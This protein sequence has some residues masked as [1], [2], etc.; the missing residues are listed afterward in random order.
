[1]KN[2][3]L[4]AAS[5]GFILMNSCQ[6]NPINSDVKLVQDEKVIAKR[7]NYAGVISIL[8]GG[9]HHCTAT[10]VSADL[11]LTA[12]HCV[13]ISSWHRGEF[14][15]RTNYKEFNIDI[16]DPT[17]RSVKLQLKPVGFQ[18]S[19]DT[20]D[21]EA[22]D[23]L[24]FPGFTQQQVTNLNA[25]P[26]VGFIRVKPTEQFDAE[27]DIWP[28]SFGA[29]VSTGK[30]ESAVTVGGFGCQT[31]TESDVGEREFPYLVDM[32]SQAWKP[33]DFFN[34][35]KFQL[36]NGSEDF[37]DYVGTG[38][39][40]NPSVGERKL[41]DAS[42]FFTEGDA[43]NNKR[44]ALCPGD[45][46]GGVY[47]QREGFQTLVIGVNSSMGAKDRSETDESKAKGSFYNVHGKWKEGTDNYFGISNWMQ[48]VFLGA[49]DNPEK[50]FA[51]GY[52][53][54]EIRQ[55]Y[56][57]DAEESG[58]YDAKMTVP[59][60][61]RGMLPKAL[62]VV[63]FNHDLSKELPIIS[64]KDFSTGQYLNKLSEENTFAFTEDIN[65]NFEV[66]VKGT[67]EQQ[68]S[69]YLFVYPIF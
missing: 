15:G 51:V 38:L 43:L 61:T 35:Y 2:I 29:G 47:L 19:S 64:V 24:P 25:G 39:Q 23:F 36:T 34:R 4:I 68:G 28:I 21:V 66:L 1:M 56:F 14:Y 20:I 27:F 16:Y 30:Y 8:K 67:A 45:S 48:W 9:K 13:G 42:F 6:K 65:G 11:I 5:S 63:A 31:K 46:G 7:E 10:R 57:Y 18:D 37:L 50:R 44:G 33:S 60:D 53:V 26:D 55:N 58:P 17:K 3:G 41:I 49:Y 32:N 12:A 69:V 40:S 62:Q 54:G 59:F 52:Q 22:I